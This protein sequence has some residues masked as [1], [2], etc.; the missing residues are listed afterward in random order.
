MQPIGTTF[1]RPARK[2]YTPRMRAIEAT[3][4]GCVIA[5]QHN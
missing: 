3:D 5:K 1:I 4:A 2:N